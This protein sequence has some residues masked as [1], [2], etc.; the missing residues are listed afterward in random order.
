MKSILMNKTVNSK[1]EM[2]TRHKYIIAAIIYLF[3]C[4]FQNF[5]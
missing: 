5:S 3:S 1:Y 2:S 4:S